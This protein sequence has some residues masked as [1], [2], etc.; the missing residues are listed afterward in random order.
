MPLHCEHLFT[1]EELLMDSVFFYIYICRKTTVSDVICNT[2]SH[3]G[4][5]NN[6]NENICFSLLRWDDRK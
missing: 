3:N 2:K 4:N 5:N 1:V 6:D